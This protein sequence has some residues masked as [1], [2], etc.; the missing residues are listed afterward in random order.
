M[1]G[2]GNF[3]HNFLH[4]C[5]YEWFK[6]KDIHT[7]LKERK[8]KKR[9]SLLEWVLPEYLLLSVLKIAPGVVGKTDICLRNNQ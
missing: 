4:S 1:A 2:N 9:T 5:C 7:P 6:K 3:V 8:K